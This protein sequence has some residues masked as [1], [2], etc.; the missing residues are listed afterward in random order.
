MHQLL[1]HNVILVRF[2]IIPLNLPDWLLQITIKIFALFSSKT[3]QISV[4]PGTSTEYQQDW[5][6]N[7]LQGL[8][9]TDCTIQLHSS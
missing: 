7:D 8:A 9:L 3:Y 2:L 1:L 4:F 6:E 5:L